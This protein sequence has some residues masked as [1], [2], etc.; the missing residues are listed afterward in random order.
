M[1]LIDRLLGFKFRST[2]I[3]RQL[4]LRKLHQEG[5][6][7]KRFSIFM[8]DKKTQDFILYGLLKTENVYSFIWEDELFTNS[9]GLV[10]ENMKKHLKYLNISEL[11]SIFMSVLEEKI[12]AIKES[13][14]N[15][16][17]DQLVQ[18]F[19]DADISTGYNPKP[20][21]IKKKMS[22]INI[23]VEN[24]I[25][26]LKNKAWLLKSFPPLQETPEEKE[27]RFIEEKN[28]RE[29]A[30]KFQ[31]KLDEI[32]AMQT[33]MS[34]LQKKL[35][36]KSNQKL[37]LSEDSLEHEQIH[38]MLTEK[39]KISEEL[40]TEESSIPQ[41]K[42]LQEDYDRMKIV[43]DNYKIVFDEWN[44]LLNSTNEEINSTSLELDRLNNAIS[45]ILS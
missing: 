13:I 21:R 7:R 4:R 32:L 41:K 11:R 1:Q 6:A 43:V 33:K 8:N 10:I 31:K 18:E 40:I 16:S 45:K 2:M 42:Q 17:M 5:L 28:A 24:K 23:N 30:A 25:K 27:K 26:D 9:T 20:E 15:D 44:K 38:N 19:K 22:R 37:R 29:E 39:M 35:S 34:A 36:I 12:N 3:D 14:R